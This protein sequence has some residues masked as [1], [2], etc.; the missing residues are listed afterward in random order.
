MKLIT[1]ILVFCLVITTARAEKYWITIELTDK[2]GIVLL[3]DKNGSR[4]MPYNFETDEIT[5][6]SYPYSICHSLQGAVI[7]ICPKDL[8]MIADIDIKDEFHNESWYYS[9]ENSNN[10]YLKDTE[11]KHNEIDMPLSQGEN[12]FDVSCWIQDGDFIPFQIDFY[13][14]IEIDIK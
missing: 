10:A 5:F 8:R 14:L 13:S 3:T 12:N 9:I 1:T 4:E 11:G 2:E 7:K 6:K